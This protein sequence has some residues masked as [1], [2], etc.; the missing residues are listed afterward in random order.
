M[1]INYKTILQHS[2]KGKIVEEKQGAS[3]VIYIVEHG[4]NTS[5]RKIAYKSV[6]VDKLTSEKKE[7][8]LDECNLWFKISNNYLV[9]PFYSK[10]IDKLPFICMPYYKLDLK[11]FMLEKEFTEIEALVI[12]IQLSKALWEMQ[13]EGVDFHQD[14]NP[15]NVL[16]DDLSQSFPDYS[17]DNCINYS[18]K[19]SDFGIANLIKRIGP[20]KGGGGGKFP[21]KAPEQYYPK[22]YD[23]Y[24]PDIFALGTMIYMLFTNKHP[25]GLSKA[26]A[27]N[28]NTSSS[29]FSNWVFNEKVIS[30]E[31]K[32]I[33]ELI[34]QALQVN[35]SG[36]PTSEIFYNTLMGELEKHDKKT[37]DN[38]KLRLD[39]FDHLNKFDTL[40]KDIDTLNK[41]SN[42]P[43]NS[44]TIYNQV[45]QIV[46]ILF[47]NIN[48]EKEL[49]KLSEYYKLLISLA[50]NTNKTH[51]L[52][53][54]SKKLIILLSKWHSKI[55][56]HHKY[57]ENKF[58]NHIIFEI[59]D[60]RDIEIVSGYMRVMYNFLSK[61]IEIQ[62][63]EEL[64]K[65]SNDDIFYSIFLYSQASLIRLSD[66]HTCIFLLSEAKKLNPTEPL[67]DYMKYLWIRN[68]LMLNKNE[69]LEKIKDITY[70]NLKDNYQNWNA[71][72]KL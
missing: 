42:L 29:K 16:I 24:N 70:K 30:L 37:Y 72:D 10:I 60:F 52:I 56:V 54:Y 26:E 61:H 32:T 2:I 51:D 4:E 49:I 31:N 12:T 28:P 55:K 5:P 18:V 35:P 33:E 23:S 43:N 25:N 50:K 8:F 67:F 6:R 9:K 38:L 19:I 20:T 45:K 64:F 66:I 17:T 21:F 36:R 40:S 65:K 39:Y 53:E 57:P 11:T 41:L 15:P 22:K 34:N 27:L 44:E 48:T 14:F 62:E 71:I 1:D 59:P 47:D 63:I 69:E 13:K 7:H 58:E 46:S 68:S 3:G